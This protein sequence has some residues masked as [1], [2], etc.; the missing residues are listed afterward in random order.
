MEQWVRA[1][2]ALT[3][4]PAK[5]AK[6]GAANA[7]KK[8]TSKTPDK[9]LA[10]R[11]FLG[12]KWI[13]KNLPRI[14]A[15][16]NV[17]VPR[18]QTPG[19]DK[20]KDII[21]EKFALADQSMSFR[22]YGIKYDNPDVPPFNHT[23]FTKEELAQFPELHGMQLVDPRWRFNK[24]SAKS[25]PGKCAGLATAM[26]V[27]FE[28]HKKQRAAYYCQ[29][30][31][32]GTV[33]ALRALFFK[34]LD[35]WSGAQMGSLDSGKFTPWDAPIQKLLSA[36]TDI[37]LDDTALARAIARLDRSNGGPPVVVNP[38]HESIA[39]GTS[40]S[41]KREPTQAAADGIEDDENDVIDLRGYQNTLDARG[42]WEQ[43]QKDINTYL[44]VTRKL[45]SGAAELNP[46]PKGGFELNA[47]VATVF[48]DGVKVCVLLRASPLSALTFPVTIGVDV[49][50]PAQ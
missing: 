24:D 9:T 18:V 23:P 22:L 28:G 37:K 2:T 40:S 20:E 50:L 7:D 29:A 11:V 6:A 44:K 21:A 3:E 26:I 13:D 4:S 16:K 15:L 42:R 32:G 39:P 46:D 8:R 35:P 47:L 38:R 45:V 31:G 14:V 19:K 36:S 49:E 12:Q 25:R 27:L 5:K 17:L 41:A 34:F 30:T 10:I 43:L 48:M 33:L 1:G